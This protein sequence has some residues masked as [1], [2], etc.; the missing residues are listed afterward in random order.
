MSIWRPTHGY[1][2]A[3][4]NDDEAHDVGIYADDAASA[5]HQRH[6]GEAQHCDP[7]HRYAEAQNE[8]LPESK[9]YAVPDYNFVVYWV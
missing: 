1:A 5:A 9:H 7:Q 2:G 6:H 4:G 3:D 8:V